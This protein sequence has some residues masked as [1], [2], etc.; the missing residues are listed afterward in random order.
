MEI[1]S[2][3]YPSLKHLFIFYISPSI[4]ALKYCDRDVFIEYRERLR[5]EDELQSKHIEFRS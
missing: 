1:A 4:T 2:I 3:K 5:I